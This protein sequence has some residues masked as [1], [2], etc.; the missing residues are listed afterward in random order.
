MLDIFLLWVHIFDWGRWRDIDSL[1]IL[2]FFL[3]NF[4]SRILI[5]NH[6]STLLY[7]WVALRIVLLLNGSGDLYRCCLVIDDVHSWLCQLLVGSWPVC[8]CLSHA[9]LTD[10]V[11]VDVIL[12]CCFRWIGRSEWV[13]SWLNFDVILLQI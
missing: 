5:L 3:D 11:G 1:F 13:V 2:R 6:K 8:A 12:I 4:S 10:A 7:L 9:H